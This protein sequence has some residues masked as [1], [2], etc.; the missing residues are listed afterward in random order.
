MP[1]CPPTPFQ[2]PVAFT[3]FVPQAISVPFLA[4]VASISP[5]PFTLVTTNQSAL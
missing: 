1:T 3:T 2:C 5:E 4:N